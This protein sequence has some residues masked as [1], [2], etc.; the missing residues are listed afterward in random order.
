MIKAIIN[1]ESGS[2]SKSKEELKEMLIQSFPDISVE[3]FRKGDYKQ[4]I[5]DLTRDKPEILIVSGGDG[6]VNAAVNALYERDIPLALIPSG[7]FNNFARDVGIPI[8][9]KRAIKAILQRNIRKVDIASVNKRFFVNN[10]SIGIYPKSVKTRDEMIQHFGYGKFL[11]MVIAFSK[12]FSKYPLYY[13]LLEADGEEYYIK[14]PF[15]FVGNNIYDLSIDNLGKRDNLNSAKLCLIYTSC[16]FR[17]CLIKNLFLKLI[18]KLENKKYL[19]EKHLESVTI[20]SKKKKLKVS[21]DGEIFDMKPPLEYKI[22]PK[23]LKV[24]VPEDSLI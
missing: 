2:E 3:Y 1:S 10:S 19:A 21:L 14:T 18:G 11:S 9:R 6:T 13:I 24:L 20:N 17:F 7:T 16:R 4:Q 15:V 22:L 12:I 5:L 23:S 8:D